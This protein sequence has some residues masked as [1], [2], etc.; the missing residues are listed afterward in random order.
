[1][2]LSSIVCPSCQDPVPVAENAA[3]KRVMC[4]R[5]G[6]IIPVPAPTDDDLESPTPGPD[7]GDSLTQDVGP[8]TW[9]DQLGQVFE[10]LAEP[11]H[12]GLVVLGM[13]LLSFLLL[14]I[15]TVGFYTGVFLSCLGL[16]IGVSGTIVC[17]LQ[18]GRGVTYLLG[19]SGTCLLA[20]VL[21][22]L[23]RLTS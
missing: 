18:H 2:T 9:R 16:F 20:L 13:G 8:L 12:L 5:C 7:I 10:A 6:E 14:C 23:P 19:G 3:K 11:R 22:L 4:L 1:M 17:L 15:P 21:V